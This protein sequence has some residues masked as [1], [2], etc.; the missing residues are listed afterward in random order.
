MTARWIAGA[1]FVSSLVMMGC[2]TKEGQ[3]L[4]E[5]D[6]GGNRLQEKK[7]GADGRYTLHAG[8]RADVTFRV[9]KGERLGFRKTSGGSVEAFAGDNPGVELDRDGARGAYWE[10]DGGDRRR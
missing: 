1:L 4:V 10:F 8:G 9:M 7:A 5:F 3:R 2:G 6:R